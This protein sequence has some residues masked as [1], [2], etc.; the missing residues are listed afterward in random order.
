MLIEVRIRAAPLLLAHLY[1]PAAFHNGIG[2]V[3]EVAHMYP[4]Y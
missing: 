2:A 3:T 4:A 1:G